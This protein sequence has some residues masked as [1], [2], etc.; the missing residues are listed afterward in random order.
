M[1]RV[2]K[3]FWI[4]CEFSSIHSD[5]LNIVKEK[6]Q[7]KLNSPEF[8]IHLTLA[9]P[10]NTIRPSSIR[11]IRGLSQEYSSI[12]VKINKYGYKNEFF[13]SFFIVVD[14]SQAL[15][16]LRK[17]IFKINQTALIDHFTPH[18]SLAYGNH[19]KHK[20]L[21]LVFS[22]PRLIDTLKI[23]RLSIVDVNENIYLWKN[24]E[25]FHFNS[26]Y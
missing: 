6:V 26:N 5:Y 8:K 18:I 12:D 9:G 15:T 10:F 13:E 3:G 16:D 22:L 11:D 25:T 24:L 17:E 20:K 14:H 23:N 21:N 7:A 1:K 19:E 4:W 2:R